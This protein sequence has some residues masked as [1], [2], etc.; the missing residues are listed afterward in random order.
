MVDVGVGDENLLELEAERGEAAVNAA[1]LVAGIDD[2]GLAGLL[3]AKDGAV[4]LQRADGKG[5][6]DH[7]S[8]LT[9]LVAS[10]GRGLSRR[11]APA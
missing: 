2:D 6:E 9:P 1:D 7:G 4:A 8:I 10:D 11:S 3:V 5:F